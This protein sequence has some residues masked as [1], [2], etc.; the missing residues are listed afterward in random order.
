MLQQRRAV[1]AFARFVVGCI[2]QNGLGA[3]SSLLSA[4]GVSPGLRESILAQGI[5]D[6]ADGSHSL[7][8]SLEWLVAILTV[9]VDHAPYTFVNRD[10]RD[11]GV[12][13]ISDDE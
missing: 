1:A 12:V 5:I 2:A 9:D 4:L 13:F 11:R 10:G 3:L 8:A 7:E 6:C